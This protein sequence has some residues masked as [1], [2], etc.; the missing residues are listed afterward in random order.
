MLFLIFAAAL[1]QGS[2]TPAPDSAGVRNPA[3][4]R[5]GRLAVSVAGDIWVVSKSGAW[6]RVTS[7]PAWDREPAW[8]SDGA[9]I[10]F[11]GSIRQFDL[12]RRDARRTGRRATPERLTS[13]PLADAEPPCCATDASC[14]STLGAARLWIRST[15]GSE[16]R[17]PNDSAAESWPA[18]SPDG[19]RIAYVSIAAASRKLHVL[20]VDNGQDSTVLT[21]A[22]VERPTWSPAGDRLAWTATGARGAVYVSPL[23]G[24]YVNVASARHAESAES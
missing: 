16:S 10:V 2:S 4:S 3:F 11:S 15:T 7:G 21:D 8:T 17:L 19:A 23:D 5:D 13:S 24:H 14:S 6:Q 9:A 22:R 18:A 12:A 20:T 1:L